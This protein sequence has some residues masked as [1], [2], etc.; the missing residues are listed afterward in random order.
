[1]RASLLAS[2]HITA[3]IFAAPRTLLTFLQPV[4]LSYTNHTDIKEK[5]THTFVVVP[6]QRRRSMS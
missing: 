2:P 6:R 3:R 4:E 1:M 5:A